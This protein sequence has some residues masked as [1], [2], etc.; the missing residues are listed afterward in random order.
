M[1]G[2]AGEG[3]GGDGVVRLEGAVKGVGRRAEL[4]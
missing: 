1:V 3:G 2:G 4:G